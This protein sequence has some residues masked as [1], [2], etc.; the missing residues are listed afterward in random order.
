MPV[1]YNTVEETDRAVFPYWEYNWPGSGGCTSQLHVE[2]A[3]SVVPPTNQIQYYIPYEETVI[4]DNRKISGRTNTYPPFRMTPRLVSRT[5]TRR[6]LLRRPNATNGY[7]RFLQYGERPYSGG[8]CTNVVTNVEIS[9]PKTARWNDVTHLFP[10]TEYQKN[11]FNM[12][13][14]DN[15]ILQAQDDASVEALTSYDFLTDLAEG[16]EIPQLVRSVTTDM[17]NILRL[18]RGRFL[19]TDLRKAAFITP[20]HLL[21]HPEKVLRK[22]GDEWMQYRYGIMPLVYSYRDI[23]KTM[24]RGVVES[25]HKRIVIQPHARNVTLPGPTQNYIWSNYVGDIRVSATVFQH[26]PLDASGMSSARSVG[27][28]LNPLVT[29][30]ELIPYSFVVDWFVNVG[31]YILR[32]TS[33]A[34]SRTIQ[35]CVSLRSNYS[36][37]YWAHYKN[38][39]KTITFGNRYSTPWVGSYPPATPSEVIKRPEESQLFKEEIVDSYDRWGFGVS[40]ARL[41]LKPNLNWKRLIDAGVM[42]LT[43]LGNL[44]RFLKGR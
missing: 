7:N 11:E 22:L 12:T 26:F 16:R 30:W 1:T 20:Q 38:E 13:D 2:S 40:D 23:M 8:V 35:A 14:V 27:V 41:Y 31:D 21:K 33:Q 6:Y 34:G 3:V 32:K 19:L 17:Y 28:G 10:Y 43:N 42:S 24:N 9:G 39:D 25:T 29:A 18:L 15:A 4:K 37:Q 5:S 36:K 44:I